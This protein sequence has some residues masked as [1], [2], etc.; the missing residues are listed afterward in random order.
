MGDEQIEV[1]ELFKHLG[2]LKSADGNLTI[3]QPAIYVAMYLSHVLD[4]QLPNG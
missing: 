2:S 3:I 1:V 4:R